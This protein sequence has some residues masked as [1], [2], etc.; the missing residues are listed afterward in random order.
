MLLRLL[1]RRLRER[2]ELL[3]LASRVADA[4][5][6]HDL[7]GGVEHGDGSALAQ[8]DARH[9]QAAGG[10]QELLRVT[11][12]GEQGQGQEAGL[13]VFEPHH[14]G[15]ETVRGVEG[16]QVE[17]GQGQV[18]AALRC[19][20]SRLDLDHGRAAPLLVDVAELVEHRVR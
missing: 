14:A 3:A 13:A 20:P 9:P 16:R 7:P 17:G 5:A 19:E 8:A 12:P 2:V 10:D 6:V 18:L 15:G 1:R 4:A 11:L